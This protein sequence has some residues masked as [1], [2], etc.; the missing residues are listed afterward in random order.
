MK[1]VLVILTLVLAGCSV[2]VLPHEIDKAQEFCKE[3]GGIQE[4]Y[5]YQLFAM[6]T[7]T[8]YVRCIDGALKGTER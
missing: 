4:I 1:T 5:R 2:S 6:D 7:P 3:H 8:L